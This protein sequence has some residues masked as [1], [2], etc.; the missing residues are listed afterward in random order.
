MRKYAR[1]RF[2]KK[3]RIGICPLDCLAATGV[4]SAT[5]SRAITMDNGFDMPVNC[6]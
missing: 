2:R 5:D 4:A 3:S 1:S 6:S